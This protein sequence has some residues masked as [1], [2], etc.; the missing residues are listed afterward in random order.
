MDNKS[1][2]YFRQDGDDINTIYNII[3]ICK[4]EVVKKKS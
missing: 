4:R 2:Q 3:I 1:K